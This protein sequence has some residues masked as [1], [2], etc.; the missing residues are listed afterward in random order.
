MSDNQSALSG[1]NFNNSKREGTT[2]KVLKLISDSSMWAAMAFIALCLWAGDVVRH[3]VSKRGLP[4]ASAIALMLSLGIASTAQAEPA[5]YQDGW[6]EGQKGA[7]GRA[8]AK[9]K[10]SS[11]NTCGQISGAIPRCGCEAGCGE[12]S[13]RLC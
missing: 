2:M 8:K 13:S 4:L 5:C 12:S 10:G 9:Y 6:S 11:C 3:L 7:F 1:I